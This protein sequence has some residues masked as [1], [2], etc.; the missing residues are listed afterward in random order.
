MNMH[1]LTVAKKIIG[2]YLAV[3]ICVNIITILLSVVDL[4]FGP[5]GVSG[6]QISYGIL[7]FEASKI[8]SI[9]TKSFYSLTIFGIIY[10]L[11][12]NIYTIYSILS[13]QKV[14]TELIDGWLFKKPLSKTI[15]RLAW[16]SLG[17]GV[18]TDVL[19]QI[20]HIFS[21][22][23]YGIENISITAGSFTTNHTVSVYLITILYVFLL[24]FI[25]WLLHYG[26]V[27]F[28]DIKTDKSESISLNDQED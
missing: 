22:Q 7:R 1:L 27:L 12:H 18:I 6:F 11:I 3:Y 17:L 8:H 5:P 25:S 13:V 9:D 23:V 24:F 2:F 19:F 10:T 14:L 21:T 26:E 15:R 20:Y 28:L 4:F 16:I